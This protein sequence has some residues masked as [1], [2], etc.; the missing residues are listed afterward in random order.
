MTIQRIGTITGINDGMA[1]TAILASKWAFPA[2]NGD[3]KRRRMAGG[4]I[5]F[6]VRE[7]CNCLR[8]GL[9]SGPIVWA[10]EEGNATLEWN[11]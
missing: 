7:K 11:N 3:E 10:V 5:W 9:K 8:P 6:D 1:S 4:G 2:S